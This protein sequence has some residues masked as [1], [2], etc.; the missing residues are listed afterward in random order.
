MSIWIKCSSFTYHPHSNECGP[1]CVLALRVM[2][3]HPHPSSH[4]LFPYM[5]KNIAQIPWWWVA[6]NLFGLILFTPWTILYHELFLHHFQQMADPYV[7]APLYSADN[8]TTLSQISDSSH[9][10]G[11]FFPPATRYQLPSSPR[12]SCDLAQSSSSNQGSQPSHSHAEYWTMNYPHL[13]TTLHR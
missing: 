8:P 5:H 12:G 10:Q 3:T 1:P 6:N 7:L 13:H 4:I 2:A 9:Q 11:L